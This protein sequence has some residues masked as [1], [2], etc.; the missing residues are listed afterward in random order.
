[1]PASESVMPD[2]ETMMPDSE[3]VMPDSETVMI[4]AG[5]SSG[6]LYGALLAM[7]IKAL[8]PSAKILGVGGQRMREAG[9]TLVAGIES[10]FGLLEAVSSYS[11][12]KDSFNKAVE[13]LRQEQPDILV[14]IDYPDYN[15]KLAREA[16]AL[17]IRKILY[18]VSP[19]IWAWRKS[20]VDLIGRLVDKVAVIL[21]FEEA[22]YKEKG[23]PAEFVGHPGLQ[24]IKGLSKDTARAGLGIDGSVPLIAILPGSRPGELK[25][26]LPV[27]LGFVRE[28]KQ[29][30]PAY[31]F[32]LPIA[33][34][35]QRGMFEELLN[36]MQAEGV[37]VLEGRAVEALSASDMVVAA[38]GTSTLQAACLLKPMVVVYRM[39][40]LT[41]AIAKAMVKVKYVSLVNLIAG[42]Q[43]VTELL[44]GRAT[45]KNITTEVKRLIEDKA[46][47]DAMVA[48]FKGIRDTFNGMSPSLR[49][50]QIVG[51]IA[52]WPR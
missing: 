28:F 2:S 52:G 17:G 39:M 46:R 4:V 12:V 45:A 29:E 10:V 3:T 38:S 1:M 9:V 14:L 36:A 19:Q 33:P 27:L 48:E 30:Y 41:Y 8:W 16:R 7:E 31:R 25:R 6:E 21:P 11:K 37:N 18:Y 24:E 26:L 42:K 5:E 23:I 49:V 35:L 40:P 15:L 44:Q 47:R 43:V 22:I 32:V 50:A 34:N 20:R 51:E 13:T